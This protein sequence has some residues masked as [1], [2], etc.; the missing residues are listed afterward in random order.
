VKPRSQADCKAFTVRI[1]A[2]ALPQS[3][4]ML[5]VR[6]F[7]HM[8]CGSLLPDS[9]RPIPLRTE[10]YCNTNSHSAPN[11]RSLRLSAPPH[12]IPPM[13]PYPAAACSGMHYRGS[14]R[15]QRRVFGYFLR[16][17]VTP[18]RGERRKALRA[19]A[20]KPCAQTNK[21]LAA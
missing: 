16:K 8:L 10:M 6:R 3:A 12:R 15:I 7:L 18:C 21:S 17:K 13:P 11:V 14:G 4:C 9:S 20:K 2:A 1:A 5:P 19:K